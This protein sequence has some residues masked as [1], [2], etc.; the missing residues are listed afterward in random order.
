MF[1]IK[2]IKWNEVDWYFFA[3]V[4]LR[5][6]EERKTVLRQEL[7]KITCNA[8]EEDDESA[9]FLD[10]VFSWSLK[11]ALNEDLY[12]HKVLLHHVIIQPKNLVNIRLCYYF[13]VFY[14]MCLVLSFVRFSLFHTYLNYAMRKSLFY[15]LSPSIWWNFESYVS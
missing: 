7:A 10:I 11:D 1:W 6:I 8:S 2:P 9:S 12:K 15:V 5:L 3:I 13:N 4:C 14:T